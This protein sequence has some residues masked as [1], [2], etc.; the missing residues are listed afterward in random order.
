MWKIYTC[1]T[2]EHDLRLVGL[3]AVVCLFGTFTGLNL[4]RRA[5]ARTGPDRLSWAIGAGF[6]TG[7]GVWATHFIAMLAYTP[8]LV[9]SYDAVLTFLSLVIAIVVMSLGY[10]VALGSL[11]PG[12]G[13]AGGAVVGIG[14]GLMHYTGMAAVEVPAQIVWSKLLVHGS[15]AFGALLATA[16]LHVAQREN[17]VRAIAFGVLLLTLGIVTLHFLGMSAIELVPDPTRVASYL[18]IAP[19]SLAIAVASVA[20]GVLAVCA[21]IGFADRSATRRL[22]IVSH[23]LDCMSQG[24]V[25][26]DGSKRLI[27]WNQRYED[28]Y[29]LHG[30]VHVGMALK[31]LMEQ[32]YAVGTLN[33][34]P[35]AYAAKAEAAA[36]SG[37]E[38]KHTFTLPDGR[39]ISGSNRP[40]PDGG[41]VSTHEDVTDR[42]TLEDRRQ[43]LERE[44]ARRDAIDREI[45]NFRAYAADL[46]S[47]VN[48]N[49]DDMRASAT[50]LL[51]SA[52][53][54]SHRVNEGVTT[55][56]QASSSIGSI[57]GAA[58]E[59]L[60]SIET[61]SRQLRAA[62]E[63]A[64]AATGEAK[65]TDEEIAG[66]AAGAGQIGEVVGLIKQIAAQ[67]NLLALNATIEA[68]RAGEAGKGFSVVAAEVK[69]LA[70]QTAR[71]TED[72]A[73]HIQGAQ[74]SSRAAV[75]A[76]RRISARM[77][78]IDVAATTAAQSVASQSLATEEIS[79]NISAA[80]DGASKVSSVLSE[81]SEAT[82]AAETT[83]EVVLRASEA[84]RSSVADLRAQVEQFLSRVAA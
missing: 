41:W 69:S 34:D 40:R 80:A 70:V 84:V 20:G 17:G 51:G 46:L 68:A 53:N 19:P 47:K 58:Q 22:A 45:E 82:H 42:Q 7:G 65:N 61:I 78:E 23:A 35:A 25:M 49:A 8:S 77:Q 43:S 44:Q 13:L 55:F 2:V 12:W 83:A 28:I 56:G 21:V 50:N 62:T 5:L 72:I 6:A 54:A 73:K 15:V 1:L 81:V 27:L 32:R 37:S 31:D 75:D 74:N 67:T 59:L 52:R 26:F 39:I 16:A 10:I 30:R 3:A 18:S 29:S 33:E 48:A 36:N 76:V 38:L 57:A 79:Q 63:K 60:M 24:L 66:L 9:V 64:A 14:V 4:F 71:A 11:G